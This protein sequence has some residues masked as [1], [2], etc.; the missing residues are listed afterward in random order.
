M[1]SSFFKSISWV[2]VFTLLSGCSGVVDEPIV[3]GVSLEQVERNAGGG[4]V[5]FIITSPAAWT[6]VCPDSW[7]RIV[8]ASGSVTSSAGTRVFLQVDEN[9]G[10][11]RTGAVTIR[12]ESGERIIIPIQQQYASEDLILQEDTYRLSGSAARL[13]IPFR[14]DNPVGVELADD[15]LHLESVESSRVVF[16][17]DEWTSLLNRIG[18]LRLSTSG[19]I[20]HEV[21]VIQGD[22][23]SDP[24][25]YAHLVKYYDRDGDGILAPDDI[26]D[27]KEI[28]ISVENDD[29]WIECFD[30][31]SAFPSLERL[32]I[33]HCEGHPK[34]GASK[35]YL[36]SHPTLKI[37][38][39]QIADF[40]ETN[41]S[42]VTTLD[43]A[44]CPNLETVDISRG[45]LLKEARI[46]DN[47]RLKELYLVNRSTAW[48]ERLDLWNCPLLELLVLQGAVFGEEPNFPVFPEL[49][50]VEMK[51]IHGLC[52]LDLS[53]SEKL[54]YLSLTDAM[55]Q[56]KYVL[57]SSLCRTGLKYAHSPCDIL[58]L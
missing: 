53:H 43:I 2:V 7:Y 24:N 56:L 52:C 1:A 13:E 48:L 16:A 37:I 39:F 21:T 8:P 51:N 15:W 9:K 33:T 46:I 45:T 29:P 57:V 28:G 50:R 55:P 12:S 41:A 17:V 32:L 4:Q 35:F 30:G 36:H 44:G 58:F 14:S 22:G 5:S 3:F 19:G 6:S 40:P 23:F 38:Q 47:P 18:T 25:L 54:N 11:E 10:F 34:Q 27:L 42:L 26:R 49:V 20:L 31:F